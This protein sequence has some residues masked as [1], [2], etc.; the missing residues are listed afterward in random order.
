MASSL[1]EGYNR[2]MPERSDHW[3][4][5]VDRIVSAGLAED[6]EVLYKVHWFGYGPEDD[7]LDPS[8][9]KPPCF[10]NRYWSQIGHMER[11]LKVVKIAGHMF[12]ARLPRTATDQ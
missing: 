11:E 1:D 12:S 3:E 10:V 7:Q 8:K 2:Y 9:N 4:F 6:G 5:V